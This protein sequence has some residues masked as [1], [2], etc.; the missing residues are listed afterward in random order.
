MKVAV[1]LEPR[2]DP[3]AARRLYEIL[4]ED[5]FSSVAADEDG[6]REETDADNLNA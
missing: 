2:I 1:T 5:G 6:E 3:T 4:F